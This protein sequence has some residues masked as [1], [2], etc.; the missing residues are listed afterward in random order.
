MNGGI[1]APTGLVAP[2]GLPAAGA[3]PL[4]MRCGLQMAAVLVFGV[5]LIW[6]GRWSRSIEYALLS[7]RSVYVESLDE[8]R[9]LALAAGDSY[10]KSWRDV[11]KLQSLEDSTVARLSEGQEEGAGQGQ[12]QG[13]ATPPPGRAGPEQAQ[14][15]GRQQRQDL[16]ATGT[17]MVV[18][19]AFLRLVTADFSSA[20]SSIERTL[21]EVGG[22]V[23][24]IDVT[25]A[26][27]QTR[28]LSATA[29][30]PADRLPAALA[31]F[32]KLGTV[33]SESQGGDD[34]TEEAT[35]LDVRLAN[36]RETERRLVLVL[37]QRTGKVGDILAVEREIAR[38]RQEIEQMSAQ[39]TNLGQRV[40]YATITLEVT[41]EEKA[42]LDLGPVSVPG[43]LRNA[44]VDGI[45]DASELVIATAAFVTHL[46]PT[47]LVL[48]LIGAWPALALRRRLR[49]SRPEEP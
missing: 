26:E 11:K 44:L 18:R 25:A 17:S 43:R 13:P 4:W 37:Q 48:V 34:V 29:R 7:S 6:A 39:R 38:V 16:T 32:R 22:F 36:A 35:D 10:S 15:Q 45:V 8:V 14:G 19:T 20:R 5:G 24:R 31:A 28:R 3:I 21:V 49:V 27:R 23:G 30:V 42:A 33:V 2:P 46:A 41:E 9:E 40:T 1:D 12:R 47:V